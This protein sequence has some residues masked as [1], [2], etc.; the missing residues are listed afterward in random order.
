M[1]IFQLPKALLPEFHALMNLARDRNEAAN[2][3]AQRPLHGALKRKNR[4][5]ERAAWGSGSGKKRVVLVRALQ[6]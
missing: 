1:F 4:V 3:R 6:M 5:R 2:S